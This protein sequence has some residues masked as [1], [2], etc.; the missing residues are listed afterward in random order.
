M[1]EKYIIYKTA[2]GYKGTTE[3]NYNA[4]IQNARKIKD[5]SAFD[6]TNDIIECLV[7]YCGIEHDN[8]IIID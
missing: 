6:N 2:F 5:F 1:D 4:R 8:I 3:E 7:K